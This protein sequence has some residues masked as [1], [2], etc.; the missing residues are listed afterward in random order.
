VDQAKADIISGKVQVHDYMSD[1]S[2]PVK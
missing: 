2:C 1:D